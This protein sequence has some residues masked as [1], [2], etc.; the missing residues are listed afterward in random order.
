MVKSPVEGSTAALIRLE[1]P[2]IFSD[3]V[4]SICLPDVAETF[5]IET[6]NAISD[7]ER[8]SQSSENRDFF[9]SSTSSQEFGSRVTRSVA[10][11]V[12][13]SPMTRPQNETN[14]K[15]AS[16][17]EKDTSTQWAMCNTLGWSKPRDHLQRV[18]L[19]IG[20]M[21]PCENISIATVNSMCTEATFHKQDC[22]EEEF[23]GSPVM[24]LMPD[25]HRWALVGIA[26]WRIACAPTGIERP[27]M[28]D[29][30]APNSAWIRRTINAV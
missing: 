8:Q 3:F 9:I 12:L 14:F 28:Y 5:S 25:S 26:S 30:I 11:D 13:S 17:P 16:K 27:R 21:E 7:A 10:G 20:N 19:K 22:T 1:T 18:Q 4:R 15:A 2:V 6:Q 24:C 29:K 23:A